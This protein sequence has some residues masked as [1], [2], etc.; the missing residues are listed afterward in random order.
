MLSIFDHLSQMIDSAAS[1]E[2]PRI[3]GRLEELK[4]R[5]TLRL[6]AVDTP[7]S[8]ASPK[9]KYLTAKEVA[10]RFP[11]TPKWLYKHKNYFT[12]IRPS[13]KLLLFPEER[14]A[15]EFA[16]LKQPNDMGD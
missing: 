5:A 9:E 8:F 16:R 7:A 15:K 2:F 14:F 6:T 3:L 10:A 13:R 4:I 12:H 1:Q 11:V